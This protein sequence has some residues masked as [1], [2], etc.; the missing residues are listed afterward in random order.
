MKLNAIDPVTREVFQYQLA[1]IAE[2]MS[3]A[4][5]RAAFSSIIWDMYDYACALFAPDGEMIAQAKSIPAQLGI[6]S[7][8]LR[9]ITSVIPLD[10]WRPGDILIC[11]DPYR[12]CTH[13][14]D[15]VLFSPIF[16]DGDLVALTSTV[17]HHVD[18]GGKV[19]CTVA[20]DNLEVFAEGL[21]I[22]PLKLVESGRPVQVIFD[23][24]AANTRN[25]TACLGDLRAQIAGCR[26]GERRIV[27]LV[28][29]YGVAEFRDLAADSLDYTERYVRR[30][31]GEVKPGRHTAEVLI[32]D[33]MAEEEPIRLVATVTVEDA[34]VTVDF[35]GTSRQRANAL[36]CPYASTV[37]MVQYAV[38]CLVASDL[39]QNDGCGRAVSVRVP[40]GTVLNPKRPAAVSTRHFTQQAVADVCLRAMAPFF[41]ERAAAGCQTSFPSL[42]AGGFDDRPQ[43]RT[44]SGEPRYYI[45]ADILGGGMGGAARTDGLDAV[46]T[47]G[48]NCALLSA[49]VMEMLSPFRVVRSELVPG[50]GGSGTHRG[51]LAVRRDYELLSEAAIL[52]AYIQQADDQT[53]PWGSNGGGS[54]AK[55]M[56]CLNPGSPQERFLR[57]KTIGH[58]LR[59]GDILRLQSAGGGG[60]GDPKARDTDAITR[61]IGEGYV[62]ATVKGG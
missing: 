32:E 56:A 54:G 44:K 41:P 8:A 40:E 60:W 12:G 24:I 18:I 49:E 7:S 61:D 3:M 27:E 33:G 14:P 28:G 15:I 10:T 37:S 9:G 34:A 13:T 16:Y 17:A 6:M 25:P 26:T 53:A 62:A 55:A 45:I 59:R 52:G 47:H 29:K 30:V 57:S 31:L 36:N 11:N 2:E 51:G 39:P 23:M 21:T 50:S 58:S 1:G 20:P 38:R 35:A 4:L 46:D 43:R 19:P 48:G 22:P 5:R 42:R